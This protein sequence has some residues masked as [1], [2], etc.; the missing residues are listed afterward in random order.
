M[1][2]QYKHSIKKIFI[3]LGLI[4]VAGLLFIFLLNIFLKWY[5]NHGESL[6]VPDFRGM[7]LADAE[8][9]ILDRDLR[10]EIK[11]STYN[12]KMPPGAIVDQNP[13]PN[14]KVKR[15]RR[16]Y[17]TINT[18]E[19]PE[20]HLPNITD[21]TS[22]R[23]AVIL[24]ESLGLKQGNLVYKDHYATNTVLEMKQDGRTLEAGDI[25]RKG[26]AIDLVIADG[27]KSSKVEIPDLT[28]MTRD[29]GVMRILGSELVVGEIL[30]DPGTEDL[31]NAIIYKQN[32]LFTP[33]AKLSRGE[34]VDIWIRNEE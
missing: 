11:D 18:A 6:T 32:P 10:M 14:A 25:V 23:Q 27:G 1:K 20:V 30:P 9:K 3:N 4:V 17:F 31:G 15:Q 13:K 28:G 24:L 22:L 21:G 5:T 19:A 29:A 12:P 2:E 26:S 8:E 7:T 33:G 16:I 34:A